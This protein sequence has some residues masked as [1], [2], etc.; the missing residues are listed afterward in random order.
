M[1]INAAKGRYLHFGPNP[2]LTLVFSILTHV[3]V[4][5]KQIHYAKDLGIL[6]DCYLI[7]STQIDAILTKTRRVLAFLRNMFR[8]LSP[9]ICIALFSAMIHSHTEYYGCPTSSVALPRPRLH[10]R[11]P[12]DV[13]LRWDCSAT[14]SSCITSNSFRFY[15]EGCGKIW[16]WLSK[17]FVA[18]DAGELFSLGSRRSWG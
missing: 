16:N 17:S 10:M 18:V 6:L 8:R 11:W 7:P 9:K 12:L 4:I 14:R 15:E 5:L 2:T 1:L 13:Y 3:A